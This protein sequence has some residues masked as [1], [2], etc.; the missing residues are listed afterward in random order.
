MAKNY[1]AL[2]DKVVDLVGGKDNIRFFTH[3]MTRLRFNVKDR[4]I[5]KMD[6]I[7]QLTEIAGAQWSGDQLQIIVGQDVGKVYNLICQKHDLEQQKAVD[8]NLDK[9]K[10]KLTVKSICSKILDYVSGSFVG[11]IPVMIAGGM[12]MTINVIFSSTLNLYTADSNLYI[13]LN[14]LYEA[15]MYFLP[16]SLGYCA[17]KKLEINPIYGIYMGSILIA[18]SLINLV[19]AGEPFTIFGVN[20]PLVNYSQSFLPS[21][22]CVWAVKYISMAVDKVIPSIFKQVLNGLVTFIIAAFVGLCFLAPIGNILA[23]YVANALSWFANATGALGV[24][25]IAALWFYLVLCGMHGTVFMAYL[26]VFLATGVETSVFP[27]IGAANIA[28]CGVI[29]AAALKMKNKDR[30]QMFFG[31]LVTE[32]L[33]GVSEPALFGL[34]LKYKK[35]FVALSVGA[36]VSALYMGITGVGYYMIPSTTNVLYLLGFAG[37]GTANLVNACI[38]YGIG[39]VAGFAATWFFAFSKEDVQA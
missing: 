18:P 6:E 34:L 29:F 2:A 7:Q 27:A 11:A 37:G 12:A 17:A 19:T 24:A 13:F 35:S 10:E 3:C 38:A 1:D 21:L 30:R 33:G 36:F 14:L 15:T 39:F 25:V 32:V 26:P 4:G 5:V 9:K 28:L 31:Y 20:M 8:E 22:I 23:N 16:V